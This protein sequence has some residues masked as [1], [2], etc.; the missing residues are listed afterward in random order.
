[1]VDAAVQSHSQASILEQSPCSTE[2]FVLLRSK[3]TGARSCRH[4]MLQWLFDGL[5]PA[6]DRAI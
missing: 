6:G 2:Q 5:V 1:M 4:A 3:E